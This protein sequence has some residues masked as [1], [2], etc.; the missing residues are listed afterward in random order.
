MPREDTDPTARVH[1]LAALAAVAMHAM[2]S[3]HLVPTMTSP[4]KP[5]AD[6]KKEI[7]WAAVEQAE[8]LLDEIERRHGGPL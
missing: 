7:A 4:D 6:V 2:W 8:A 3:G 5:L 1:V